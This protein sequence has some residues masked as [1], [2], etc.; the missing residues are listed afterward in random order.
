M[1]SLASLLDKVSQ[2]QVSGSS[3]IYSQLLDGLQEALAQR[4][5]VQEWKDFSDGLSKVKRSMAPL[6]NVAGSIRVLLNA[7]IP[8]EQFNGFVKGFLTDLGEREAAAPQKIA[9]TLVSTYR[10]GKVVTISYSGTVMN[11][12]LSL[13]K[14]VE[15][16]VAESLPMGEGALTCKK[17]ADKG[18]RASLFRDSMIASE[19]Q[20][21]DLVL[22]GADG[23][24]PEG[25]VNKVGTMLVALAAKEHGKPFVVLCSTSKLIP[26]LEMD[27]MEGE[28]EIQ[29]SKVKE[30][31]F[32]LTPLE[33][34]TAVV[35]D[36]GVLSGEEMRK[37]LLKDRGNMKVTECQSC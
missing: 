25:V 6:Q 18:R 21:S 20:R 28:S 22:V 34:V 33:M 17:L 4:P 15:I 10:P 7:Q 35:T 14:D 9:N 8:D 24:C 26:V 32:D 12:L 5:K 29:G 19:V 31:I 23:V 27:A 3:E 16:S 13:P 2:D 1:T 37:R 11:S 36:E 30:S